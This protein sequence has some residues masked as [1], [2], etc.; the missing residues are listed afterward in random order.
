MIY[1]DNAATSRYKPQQ[2]I[3]SVTDTLLH[4][5]FNPNRGSNKHA[6]ELQQKILN[7]RQVVC[8]LLGGYSAECT[9][10]TTNTTTALNLAILGHARQGGH[11]ITTATEHNSVLRP[12]HHLA[13]RGHITL[14]IVPPDKDG[15]V[16]ASDLL[17][18]IR[19][20][21]YMLIIC[22]TSNVT[23]KSQDAQTLCNA[24]KYAKPDIITLLDCAQSVGHTKI[25]MCKFGADMVAIPAHKGLHGVQGVGVLCFNPDTQPRPIVFGGTGTESNNLYQPDTLPESLESGTLNC[26]A[27][28]SLYPAIQWW[29]DNHKANLQKV[30]AMQQILL[31]G[32][33]SIHGIKLYSQNNDC[34]IVTFNIREYDST[35]VADILSND[36]DIAVR[37]GIHCA[38]LMHKW[39]GTTDSGAVRLSLGCDNT[40]HECYTVLNAIERIA[41]NIT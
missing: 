15:N 21:T 31:D 27:I 12:L 41:K 16:Q 1:L 13:R 17:D 22:H 30:N 37:G 34:G 8:A 26:P 11:I 7:T 4:Y 25:D 10:F 28:V 2:V 39:L 24:V 38:P 20:N 32:L 29:A 33:K 23:G 9:V 18:A 40:T 6:Q 3:D 5:S 14:T 36:Y 19:P 35:V